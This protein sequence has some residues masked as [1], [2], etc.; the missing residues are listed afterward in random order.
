M[1]PPSL[2]VVVPSLNAADTIG[3][4]LRSLQP[5]VDAGA[6]V[7]VVD[8]GSTDGTVEAARAVGVTVLH[9]DGGMYAA[10]NA[11]FR[12]MRCD[13]LTWINADD[14]LYCSAL[15]PRF[16]EAGDAAVTYGPVDF[17]DTAGRFVHCWRSARPRDL[18][19]L[20]RA[21]YSPLLQQGTLFHHDVYEELGGFVEDY[22]LVADA[23]FWWRAL[24]RGFSFH[25]SSYP[26][27]AGFRLHA[28]QLSQ[29]RAGDM[30]LEHRRM[31]DAHGGQR[32][33]PSSWLALGRHRCHNLSGY[34][35]RALRRRDLEGHAR[36]VASYDVVRDDPTIRVP[37]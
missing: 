25:R 8:G 12:Q 32:R 27:V 3:S 5:A 17:L 37:S 18:L 31:V 35:V 20:Y 21:G 29:R 1:S 14:L 34:V 4:T 11:G 6:Q 19:R 13:W 26:P 2:G 24:E 16:A 7:I 15:W 33:T 28:A 22:R 36:L 9:H 10:L 30:K 23:D